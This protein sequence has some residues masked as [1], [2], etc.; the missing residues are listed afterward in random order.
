[1]KSHH[2]RH[3]KIKCQKKCRWQQ[4]RIIDEGQYRGG[5]LFCPIRILNSKLLSLQIV[6]VNSSN[7]PSTIKTL[8][9]TLIDKRP[10]HKISKS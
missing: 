2:N 10:S 4:L 8:A 1:M 5:I 3:N 7:I 6:R 9:D